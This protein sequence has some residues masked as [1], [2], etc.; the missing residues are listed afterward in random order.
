MNGVRPEIDSKE[1]SRPRS[2]VKKMVGSV[3]RGGAFGAVIVSRTTYEEFERPKAAAEAGTELI[4]S[5]LP[6][7]WKR[8]V[9]LVDR[10]RTSGE[11]ARRFRIKT[12][13]GD[14]DCRSM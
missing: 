8:K 12:V 11:N 4:E 14:G 13:V 10:R 5:S 6:R 3:R 9:R 2:A 1:R 7:A